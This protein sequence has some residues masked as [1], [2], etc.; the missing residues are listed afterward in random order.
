L[1]KPSDDPYLAAKYIQ[2]N[3]PGDAR[4]ESFESELFFLAPEIMF[5]YPS[6]LVSMQLIRKVEIDLSE[7]IDYNPFES[8][9]D[10]LVVGPYSRVWELYK[11]VLATGVFI[12]DADIGGYEIYH[13]K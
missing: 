4:V 13:H 6:D 10:Y 5:H 1:R 9:P 12:L 8:N 3:I 2:Q 11:D 7:T